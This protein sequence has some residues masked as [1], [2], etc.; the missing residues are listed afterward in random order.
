M[1]GEMFQRRVRGKQKEEGRRGKRIRHVGGIDLDLN[2]GL[3][4]NVKFSHF[5]K[6]KS[7]TAVF[8]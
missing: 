8:V 1:R 7:F 4:G 2:Q 3:R 5:E 6:G